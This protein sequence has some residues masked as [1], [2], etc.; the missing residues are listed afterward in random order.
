[1]ECP[2]IP[3]IKYGEF[4]KRIHEEAIANRIPING[5]IE[6]TYRCNLNCVHCYCNLPISDSAAAWERL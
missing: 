1:M 2:H 3:E 4:S 6:A 5:T